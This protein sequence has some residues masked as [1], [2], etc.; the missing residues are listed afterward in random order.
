MKCLTRGKILCISCLAFLQRRRSRLITGMS[1]KN[2]NKVNWM[3]K[4]QAKRGSFLALGIYN[5]SCFSVSRINYLTNK[6]KI[7]R[8]TQILER[9]LRGLVFFMLQRR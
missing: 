3:K 1:D 6:I 4:H 9:T 7:I 5:N 8:I 2:N